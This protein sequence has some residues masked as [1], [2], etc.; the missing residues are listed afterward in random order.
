M[1]VTLL[2]RVQLPPLASVDDWPA[3]AGPPP[4]GLGAE[5]VAASAAVR[6]W[7]RWHVSPVITETVTLHGVGGHS[8]NLP[9]LR[10]VEVLAVS[11]TERGTGRVPV[12]VDLNPLTTDV[13][14][15]AAGYLY[16]GACWPTRLSGVTV[17]M[18]H[19]YEP[20]EVPDLAQLLGVMVARGLGNPT[21]VT[22][23]IVGSLQVQY[24]RTDAGYVITGGALD[25]YLRP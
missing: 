3:G 15:A 25:P 10:L 4:P 6:R 16:R 20:A 2:P 8:L 24:A 7:C 5:L 11:V 9:T 23:A 17:T 22:Q 12:V 21:G 1:D 19:G 13:E 18:R 14:A